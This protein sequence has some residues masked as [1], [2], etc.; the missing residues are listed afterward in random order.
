M[1]ALAGAFADSLDSVK[2]PSVQDA[3]RGQICEIL[4][5][6]SIKYNQSILKEAI[7]GCDNS[8]VLKNTSVTRLEYFIMLNSAFGTLPE[9][10]GGMKMMM[11]DAV[12]FGDVP[13]WA[14]TDIEKIIAARILT[15]AQPLNEN[16]SFDEVK[17]LIQRIHAL[18]GTSLKDDFYST[19]NKENIENASLG[20]GE[21]MASNYDALMLKSDEDLKNIVNE[22]ISK[23]HDEGTPEQ[24]ITD[25]Y[26][27]YLNYDARDKEGVKP[28]QK[29]LDSLKSVKTISELSEVSFTISKEMAVHI[30]AEFGLDTDEKESNK[31]ILTFTPLSPSQESAFYF[32]AD[33]E[34]KQIYLL[35]FKTILEMAGFNETF[36]K[37]S[38]LKFYYLEKK[39]AGLKLNSQ[40]RDP[41]K[42][43][44]IYSLAQLKAMIP[45]LDFDRLL[46]ASGYEASDKILIGEVA[47]SEEFGR[48]YTEENIELLKSVAI[49]KLI[50]R[51]AP[52]LGT[53]LEKE[54][55]LFEQKLLGLEG[56]MTDE[57]K[58]LDVLK[59]NL[60]DYLAQK[61]VEKHF[62]KEEK[63][64]VEHMCKEYISE[65]KQRISKIT[66]LSN[67]T[68]QKALSK[69]DAMGLEVGYPEKYDTKA[70]D[71]AIIRSA[72][73]GGSY[74]DN[75]ISINIEEQK[76][77][78]EKQFLPVDKTYWAVSPYDVNAF[79]FSASNAIFIPAAILK[80]PLYDKD[81]RKEVNYAGVG[82]TIG[83]EI[84]H[85][86]DATGSKYD[87][88]GNLRNWWTEEEYKV[89]ERLLD[90]V[91]FA[92][93]GYEVVP[94]I[95]NNGTFTL[96]ENVADLGG[97]ASS[98]SLIKKSQDPDFDLFFRTW[99]SNWQSIL[100][101]SML[102]YLVDN[103]EHSLSKARANVALRN[104]DEFYETYGITKDDF[105]YIAPENRV[106]IW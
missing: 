29:Y 93:D 4:F 69:L 58:A 39:L 80:P 71:N 9:P 96:S 26:R 73:E 16:V 87:E 82:D 13:K 19:I 78:V 10:K 68:K 42:Y 17:L 23:P 101:R 63:A 47:L 53:D 46:S 56:D 7:T 48:L 45:N 21:M 95:K 103:D 41:D 51:L 36:S 44:N 83:H 5:T 105:S 3:S 18:L 79:Y 24:K 106:V 37:E 85:A 34:Q 81:K 67:T 94:G 74:F 70:L 38:S 75:V 55:V 12:S 35:H 25:L 31:R 32:D 50:T 98:L 76:R 43:Y 49:I 64:D 90:N 89:F 100:P 11:P 62:S 99:T 40:E 91:I 72:G 57:D 77:E 102:E 52:M 65:Q 86:F 60:G 28:I 15:E 30:F 6:Q 92:Y 54:S 104:V 2:Q 33:G 61:Y 88:F 1:L 14:K 59:E 27:N 20:P 66:W 22:I 8:H 97:L 84:T